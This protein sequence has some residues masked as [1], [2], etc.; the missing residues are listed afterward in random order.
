V[1]DLD[2]AAVQHFVDWPTTRPGRAGRLCDRSIA[3]AL[4]P[5]RLAL[6]AAVAEGL[7]DANPA[8]QIVLPRRRAG[9]AWSTR[10]RRFLTRAELVRLLDEVPAKWRPLFELLAAT[11][12][13]I[14]EAIG[15]R[16]SDL[17][18]D[19]PVPHLHV[20]R[21]IVKGATV[22][23]KSR[24][25]ARL[26]PLT[27]ELAATLRAHR[28]RE[29]A[30]DAFVFPGRDADASDPGSL[31][32]RVFVPA[33]DRA[34]LTGVGFHT[35]RHTCASMLIESGLTPLRLQ[36]R[37][38]HHSPA[39]TLETYGHL[40]D[41]DLGPA[42]DLRKRAASGQKPTNAAGRAQLKPGAPASDT[43][44]S[45]GR[46]T[47]RRV[48]VVRSESLGLDHSLARSRG[49]PVAQRGHLGRSGRRPPRCQTR[50]TRAARQACG[51][52]ALCTRSPAARRGSRGSVSSRSEPAHQIG[53]PRGL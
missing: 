21:A 11:G 10:E 45:F 43:K 8:E 24:H 34:G 2:R 22:A 15:L 44:R 46:R 9:R 29:A 16:W 49:N 36:R 20:R 32:R 6:D 33:A 19:G 47:R 41:D 53:D 28:P 3:N 52:Q 25:G 31:R 18:L 17:G 51:Q 40:I 37:M 38:G 27:P 50:A 1:R 23:P 48:R 26:I 5:L 4:T 12:L 7:L 39:F 13:R 14:S 30:D 35:L 42:L